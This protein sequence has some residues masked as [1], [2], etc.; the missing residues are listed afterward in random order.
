MTILDGVLQGIIQGLTEFLPVS[1]DGHLALFQHL[2]GLSGENALFFTVMLHVGTLVAVFLAFY[3]TI[4]K[5]IVEAFKMIGDIFTRKFKYKESNEERKGVIMILITLIPLLGFFFVKD[6]FAMLSEDSDIIVEGFCFLFTGTLLFLADKC[7]KGRKTAV[8]MTPRD[9][10]RI[11]FFQG[12]AALPGVSR[13]GSTIS[14]GLLSGFSREFM[15]QFSFIMGIPAIMGASLFEFLDAVKE[16][17]Q[18]S[19]PLVI[20]MVVSA[21][22]GL[23]A[24]KLLTW[25][26]KTDRFGIFAY[27]TLILGVIVLI[28]GIVEHIAGGNIV[29]I[30]DSLIHQGVR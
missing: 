20:G 11:G 26:V 3:K 22:V 17:I 1:S 16:G 21:V 15:V 13:S 29:A 23:L 6:Y 4:W 2:F 5:M 24:I 14:I 27:Y 18:F 10:L 30:V 12:F 7:V 19:L 8:D 25:L 28:I 9:A